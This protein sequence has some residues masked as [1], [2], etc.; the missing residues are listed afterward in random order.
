MTYSKSKPT[1]NSEQF[2]GERR[3]AP[4]APVWE[5]LQHRLLQTAQ[6]SASVSL[7][8]SRVRCFQR[9]LCLFFFSLYTMDLPLHVSRER[10]AFRMVIPALLHH[11][12]CGIR[13]LMYPLLEF[14]GGNKLLQMHSSWFWNHNISTIYYCFYKI[15]KVIRPYCRL[16]VCQRLCFKIKTI[17]ELQKC[18]KP[19]WTRFVCCFCCLFFKRPPSNRT[20]V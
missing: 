7:Y 6:R 13:V 11:T 20:V 17:S 16:L 1:L 12:G 19:S 9:Q 18:Q 3:Q 2:S 10:P 8:K 14:L 4:R 15:P 5:R